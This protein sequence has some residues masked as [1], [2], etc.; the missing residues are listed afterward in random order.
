M[1]TCSILFKKL[2]FICTEQYSN[3]FES[4]L[5]SVC[6]NQHCSSLILIMEPS[7]PKVVSVNPLWALFKVIFMII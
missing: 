3:L 6:P 4:E 1:Q 2:Y 5:H 7:F